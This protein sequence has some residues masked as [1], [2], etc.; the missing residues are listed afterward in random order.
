MTINAGTLEIGGAG[1]LVNG[2][3]AGAIS[4]AGTFKYN[5]TNAQSSA[6]SSAVAGR[7]TQSGA[8][9]LTLS[10]ANDYTGNTT[11]SAG[12]LEVLTDSALG[13]AAGGTVVESGATLRLNSGANIASEALTL[14]GTLDGRTN[15][16]DVEY[17]GAITLAANAEFFAGGSGTFTVSGTVDGAGNQLTLETWVTGA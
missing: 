3:Y 5:S 2:N 16:G 1:R 10:G 11:V 6:A 7:L 14:S 13:T 17:G 9:T 12:I 15:G 4:N 8:G